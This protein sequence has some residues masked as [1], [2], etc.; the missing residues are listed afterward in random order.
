MIYLSISRQ[1]FIKKVL[2]YGLNHARRY[3]NPSI[4]DFNESGGQIYQKR[5]HALK[6]AYISF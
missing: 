5:K 1:A 6:Q 2:D 3:E 4:F